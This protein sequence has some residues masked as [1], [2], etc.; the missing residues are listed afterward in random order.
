[1]SLAEVQELY[2]ILVEIDAILKGITLKTMEL[3]QK[4]PEIESYGEEFS[5]LERLAL[6]W[7]VITRKMG[8]PDDAEQAITII[9]K[10]VVAVKMAVSSLSA[11]ASA[12]NPLALALGISGFLIVGLTL[13]GSIMEGY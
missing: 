11:I 12:A 7:L 8:L 6:R 3:E 1:M 4:A 5:K 9:A 2:N 13:T 10:Y